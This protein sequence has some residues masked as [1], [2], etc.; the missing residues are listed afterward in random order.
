MAVTYFDTDHSYEEL[1]YNR[2]DIEKVHPSIVF[3]IQ[4]VVN[5]LKF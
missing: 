2:K 3:T 4:V 5:Y 1:T